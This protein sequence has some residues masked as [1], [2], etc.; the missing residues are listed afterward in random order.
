VR[1]LGVWWGWVGVRGFAHRLVDTALLSADQAV[2]AII[3]HL[4]D[5]GFEIKPLK[6]AKPPQPRID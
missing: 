4:I 5:T 6:S 1:A 3:Q 2:E